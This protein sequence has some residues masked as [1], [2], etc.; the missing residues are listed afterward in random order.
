MIQHL[1]N[2]QVIALCTSILRVINRLVMS[3]NNNNNPA[4]PVQINIRFILAAYMIV[5]RPQNVFET[6]GDSE[7]R[8]AVSASAFTT[9]VESIVSLIQAEGHYNA[10]PQDLTTTFPEI[11]NAYLT[12]FQAW[13]TPDLAKVHDR[14]TNA[15][16]ALYAAK[17]YCPESNLEPLDEQINRLRAKLIELGGQDSL[18]AFDADLLANPLP[19]LP[20]LPATVDAAQPMQIPSI[21]SNRRMTNEQL[22]HELFLNESFQLSAIQ[23]DTITA[24]TQ[25][26]IDA[27]WTTLLNE[28]KLQP[29]PC[30]TNVYRVL[31]DFQSGICE[32]LEN[33]NDLKDEVQALINIESIKESRQMFDNASRTELLDKIADII[34]RAQV[35]ESVEETRVT[36][37]II[38]TAIQNASSE[39]QPDAICQALKFFTQTVNEMR[40]RAAN[41]RLTMIAP[42]IKSHG[43]EYL[44]GKFQEKLDSGVIT[45]D[46]TTKWLSLQIDGISV[47]DLKNLVNGDR[48][49]LTAVYQ[50]ALV[51]IIVRPA[52]EVNTTP[53]VFNFDLQRLA[54]FSAQY[55]KLVNCA[56]IVRIVTNFVHKNDWEPDGDQQ[57]ALLASMSTTVLSL[58]PR[59]VEDVGSLL[60]AILQAIPQHWLSTEHMEAM[61]IEMENVFQD[62]H[63]EMRT[64]V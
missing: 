46:N 24:V 28:S 31:D 6:M 29:E 5:S 63:F 38:Q 41:A 3:R 50:S 51:D 25:P 26:L 39:D 10:I 42:V 62:P 32:I 11:L 20:V 12:D 36:W 7:N 23:D 37:N 30:Y 27:F 54:Y 35:Q 44:H 13:K 16:R 64:T 1:R 4:V 22:A 2:E 53:E 60:D 14:I 34:L 59:K 61:R 48:S 43:A 52:A 21:I 15:L 8:L 45:L 33:G 17:H 55:Q 40:V 19:P 58:N 57:N 18:D 56:T 49:T 47:R 9:N